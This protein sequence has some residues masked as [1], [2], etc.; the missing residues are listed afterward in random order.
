MPYSSD[1]YKLL[2]DEVSRKVSQHYNLTY[3]EVYEFL[4]NQK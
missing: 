4:Q 1:F 2:L 3:E